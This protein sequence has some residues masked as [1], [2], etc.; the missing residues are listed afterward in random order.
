MGPKPKQVIMGLLRR[1]KCIS[2]Q[3]SV[4]TRPENPE[5]FALAFSD[6]G[7]ASWGVAAEAKADCCE[8][9]DEGAASYA[10]REVTFFFLVTLS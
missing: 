7:I 10:D 1:I 9:E 5:T 2:N 3:N 6:A 8:K 4:R